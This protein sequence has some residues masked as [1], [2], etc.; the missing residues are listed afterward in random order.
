MK[1]CDVFC[2]TDAEG[3]EDKLRLQQQDFIAG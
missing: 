1:L 3:E 2:G